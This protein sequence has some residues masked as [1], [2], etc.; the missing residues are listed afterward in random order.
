MCQEGPVVYKPSKGRPDPQTGWLVSCE[1]PRPN[2][3]GTQTS[4]SPSC[5][6][7]CRHCPLP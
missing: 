2:T 1:D 4:P 7:S 3:Q 6:P 5:S